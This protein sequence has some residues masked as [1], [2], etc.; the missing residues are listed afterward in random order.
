MWSCWAGVKCA[1]F[2]SQTSMPSARRA[3]IVSAIGCGPQHAGVGDQSEAQCLIDLVIEMTASDV[4][5][6]HEEQV[7]PARKGIGLRAADR[8]LAT[9]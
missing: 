1:T 5:L 2:S 6:M 4:A 9:I 7:V 3:S 8:H